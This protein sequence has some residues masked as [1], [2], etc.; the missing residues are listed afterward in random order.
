[1]SPAAVARIGYRG[2][3]SGRRVVVAGLH[4]QVL[5]LGSRYAPHA[6]SLPVVGALMPRR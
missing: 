2:L 5:A 1:M 3:K 4:N 6:V